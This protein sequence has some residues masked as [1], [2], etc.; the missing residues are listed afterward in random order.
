MKN[1]SAMLVGHK[2]FLFLSGWAIKLFEKLSIF[3]PAHPS[4]YLMTGPLCTWVELWVS[5]YTR[6][7][8]NNHAE[9]CNNRPFPLFLCSLWFTQCILVV[10]FNDRNIC[11]RFICSII[12]SCHL[13]LAYQCSYQNETVRKQS[14]TRV[15]ST[16]LMNMLLIN[17]TKRHK[18]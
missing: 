5:T 10:V 1:F 8:L 16:H 11:L 17:N 3:P 2:N 15:P 4:R 14:H 18:S 12:R 7:F 13:E 9:S 6:W